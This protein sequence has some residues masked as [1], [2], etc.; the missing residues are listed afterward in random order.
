MPEDLDL[1]FQNGE[2]SP[3]VMRRFGY[4]MPS[5]AGASL[6]Q[7]TPPQAVQDIGAS[8][9]EPVT[10]AGSYLG[11]VLRTGGRS[12]NWPETVQIGAG[13]GAMVIPGPGR[14]AGV[15]E[16]ALPKVAEEAAVRLPGIRAY[17]GSPYDFERFDLSK[18]GTGEGAQA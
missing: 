8:L 12:F 9:V 2:I 15:V 18:I 4:E 11:D 14:V 5:A 16:R 7:T 3:D 17:H 13:L 10:R 6:T 1:L